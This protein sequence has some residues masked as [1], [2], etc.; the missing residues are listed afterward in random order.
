MV[1][2]TDELID[3]STG[4]INF[5]FIIH[6]HWIKD[7]QAKNGQKKI[8]WEK[9]MDNSGPVEVTIGFF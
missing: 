6:L 5:H 4:R 2:D 9:S 1:N 3:Q 7:Q 8:H